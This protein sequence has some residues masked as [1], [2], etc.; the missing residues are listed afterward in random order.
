[1]NTFV[2]LQSQPAAG[3]GM[4]AACGGGIPRPGHHFPP[5]NAHIKNRP[6]SAGRRTGRRWLR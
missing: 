5:L 6:R 4:R 3:G 2:F 1:M